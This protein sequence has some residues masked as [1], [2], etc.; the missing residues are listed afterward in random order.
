M[1]SPP[2]RL[3]LPKNE[4]LEDS[5]ESI[6]VELPRNYSYNS[7]TKPKDIYQLVLPQKHPGDDD[8]EVEA[9]WQ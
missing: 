9:L 5:I 6:V 4:C 7:V 1:P 8:K 3:F 2:K